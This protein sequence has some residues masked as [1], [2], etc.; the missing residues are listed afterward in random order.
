MIDKLKVIIDKKDKFNLIIFFFLLLI[1]TFIEMIGLGSLPIFAM[2]IVDSESLIKKLPTFFTYDFVNELSQKK[3]IIYLSL[4][5]TVIFLVKNLFLVF[6]NFFNG[7]VIKRI[8]ENLTNRLFKNYINSNYEFH[9][10]RNSADLIRNVYTEVARSIYYLIG[11]ISLI[12]ET[13]ILIVILVLLI[14]ADSVGAVLIFGFL[15][16][17][18]FLFFLYTRNSSKVRGKLIQE[19]WGKQTKT[20]KHGLGSIKEIKMLNKE[21]FIS[22]IFDFNTEMIEK[23]NFIQSFIVTLPRLFLEVATILAITIVCSLFVI[24]DKSVEN[25]IPVI[26][27]I[28]VSA[29]RLIPSFSTISQSIA[30]IKYQSPAFNLIVKE[31][32]EM[33]KATTYLREVDQINHVDILFKKKIEIKNLIFKY[34]LTEKKVID[35]L[36]ININKGETIGIAGA[37]GE[38]KSTLLDLICGLLKPTSGQ[39]LVDEIDINLKKNNWKSKIGYVPQDIY[40]LDDTIKSNIAFGVNDK[41]FSSSQFQKSIKMSQLSEFLNS[42]PDK[43]LT[44]VGDDGVRLSGGQKQRIGIARSLY[45]SPEVLILDEP[46]SALDEKNETLILNDIYNIKSNIT[47][48]IISHRKKVFEKCD[49]VIEIKSGKIIL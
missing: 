7:L 21:N 34:P 39:I 16:F 47:L 36:S 45:F 15:G 44:Y 27:L 9:I 3:L 31:L 6:V 10:S 33:K 1:A 24:S 40:L 41:S 2:A 42:L 49:K 46:T 11:H 43:E 8:R 23:F 30:T 35:N 26:V 38:G 5:I 29:I 12:K 20:L 32:D 28:S 37:S 19:Y 48:V 4:T 17:F 14:I 18:S 22:K 25:I 13:L